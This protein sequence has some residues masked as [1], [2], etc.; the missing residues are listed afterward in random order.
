MRTMLISYSG[1]GTGFALG[2]VITMIAA[3]KLWIS[4]DPH[5]HYLLTLIE[6]EPRNVLWNKLIREH[7]IEVVFDKLLSKPKKHATFD[8]RLSSRQIN[9]IGFETYRELYTRTDGPERQ[10][11]LAGK[12][13]CP[14]QINIIEY[15][16][17]GQ[18]D[19]MNS[20]V[21]TTEFPRGLIDVPAI[22]RD[23]FI[24]IA[25]HETC[26]QNKQFTLVFWRNVIQILLSYGIDVIV[27]DNTEFM[28]DYLEHPQF[29]KTFYDIEQLIEQVASVAMVACGNT[30][31]GWLAAATETP[32]VAMQK[33]LILPEYCFQHSGCSSLLELVTIPRPEIAAKIILKH[34]EK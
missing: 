1:S 3:A 15:Y 18:N 27:N 12:K 32:F 20:C 29:T 24:L 33:N 16:L 23:K 14:N 10:Q 28:A 6:N 34:L 17:L 30:G 19:G 5:E 25:P 21:D 26:H 31:I 4:H 22:A 7:K 9:G 13:V 2:D 8:A 11:F